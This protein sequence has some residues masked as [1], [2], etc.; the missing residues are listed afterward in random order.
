MTPPAAGRQTPSDGKVDAAMSAALLDGSLHP[1]VLWR[2]FRSQNGGFQIACLYMLFEYI[3]PQSR[4]PAIDILPWPM[5]I[6]LAGVAAIVPEIGRRGLTK[7]PVNK[8]LVAYFLVAVISLFFCD[9]PEYGISEWESLVPWLVIFVLMTNSVTSRDKFLLLLMVYVLC[10]LRLSQ[11]GLRVFVF[12]GFSM[13]GHGFRGP[14]GWFQNQGELGIQMAMFVPI[15]LLAAYGLWNRFGKA[16]K[17]I[18]ALI[19]LSALLTAVGT[20]SRG[21]IIAAAAAICWALL[22]IGV[23]FRN[24]LLIAVL[25]GIGMFVLSDDVILR[26]QT[27]G[28]DTTSVRRLIFI[29]DGLKMIAE[30]PLTGIGYFNWIPYYVTN[31]PAVDE[32]RYLGS[33]QLPH[34]ILIQVTAELGFAG[35]WVF[36]ML[37]ISNFTINRRTRRMLGSENRFFW[38]MSHG[39][40]ASMAA[41]LIA[42]QFVTVMYYPYFWITISLTVALHESCRRDLVGNL[43]YRAPRE[44]IGVHGRNGQH[45]Q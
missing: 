20:H 6:I 8:W 3:R 7:T 30:H 42:G 5:L 1:K 24:L 11:F 18:L 29:Q 27:M 23:R 10:N 39:L 45:E 43:T 41:F 36:I 14:V 22:V 33:H 21:A 38:L 15:A 4:F 34:N 12:S 19:P 13:P 2:K 35:L 40:D 17:I 9:F 16:G 28:E 26:F 32:V 31:F 44:G 37:V 25:L